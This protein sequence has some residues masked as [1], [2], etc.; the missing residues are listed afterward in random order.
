M[1]TAATFQRRRRDELVRRA[2]GAGE[3]TEVFDAASAR[4]RRL[5]PFDAAVWVA[6]DPATGLPAGPTRAYD[7]D[8]LTAAEC[9]ALWRHEFV[10][11]DVN[12][13]SELVRD[14]RLAASLH[15]AA[16]DPRRSGRY[17]SFMRPLGFEDELRAVLTVGSG[18]WG[19]V[20]LWRRGGQP[21]FSAEETDLVASVAAPLAEALRARARPVELPSGLGDED[22]PG[23]MIFDTDGGLVSA[24]DRALAWLAELP[25]ERSVPNAC[26]ADQ[27]LWLLVTVLRAAAV[28]RGV[29]DGTARARVRQR[30]GRWLVGHASCTAPPDGSGGYV[31]VVLGPATPRE[32]ALLVVEAYDLTERE[33][34]ITGLIARGSRTADI[35]A[36]LYVSAHTVRDHVKTIFQ[37]VGVSSRGELVATLYA[38]HFEPAREFPRMGGGVDRS[39]PRR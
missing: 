4:L 12:R 21:V 10:D 17:R 15:A 2:V 37:K 24:D 7:L 23:M 9:S 33:R 14:S 19:L 8:A 29:G 5:V 38:Q 35:A 18:P 16:D 27:P 34:Q 26:G 13:F 25:P 20:T 11:D 28:V 32:I 36:E 22:Q 1:G 3:V 31:A 6:T 30:H 39:G